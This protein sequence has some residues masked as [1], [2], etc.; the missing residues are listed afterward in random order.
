M[1]RR[2]YL[3]CIDGHKYCPEQDDSDIGDI[4]SRAFTALVPHAQSEDRGSIDHE[5]VDA[6]LPHCVRRS[7]PEEAE[8]E[9]RL[10]GTGS[11]DVEDSW[12]SGTTP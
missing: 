11:A 5:V 10:D 7:R 8:R 4:L 3:R 9:V 1:F 6:L 2:L 12:S